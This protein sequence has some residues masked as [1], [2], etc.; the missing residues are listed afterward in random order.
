LARAA[1]VGGLV[2][3]SS[4]APAWASGSSVDAARAEATKLANQIDTQAARVAAIDRQLERARQWQQQTNAALQQAEADLAATE[5][6]MQASRGRLERHAVDAYVKGGSAVV[7]QQ[8]FGAKKDA[9]ARQEY[10]K[11][12]AAA[13]RSAIDDLLATRQD[14]EARRAAL[15]K[16]RSEADAAAAAFD[17]QR[18]DEDRAI[19]AQRA[20]LAKAKG[21]LAA[22]LA[23]EQA[24]RDAAARQRASAAHTGDLGGTFACIRQLES[25]NN[26]SAP[27]GGAYQFTDDTWHRLGHSGTASD[28]PPAEQDAAAVELQRQDGWGPWTTAPA[29]GR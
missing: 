19:A 17:A 27:G 24:R 1:L 13:D 2:V 22:A 23:A 11:L 26:Y 3:V 7:F 16:L 14:L 15:A 25:S 21:D 4:V 6:Q 20:L 29:C 8:L 9:A 10:V 28:A 12:A 5:A 18:L